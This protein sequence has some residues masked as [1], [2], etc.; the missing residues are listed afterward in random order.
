M[1]LPLSLFLACLMAGC[2]S[3]PLAA[4]AASLSFVSGDRSL[5][6][7]SGIFAVDDSY[8]PGGP[9]KFAQVRPGRRNISYNCPGFVFVDA[10]PSVWHTF[11]SRAQ[12]ELFCKNGTPAFRVKLGA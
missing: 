10:P 3:E 1:R 9:M 11:K 7:A 12:Y 6:Q 2:A 4:P 8:F 5:D